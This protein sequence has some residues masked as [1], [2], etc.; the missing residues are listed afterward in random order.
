MHTRVH[1][2]IYLLLLCMTAVGEEDEVSI[3]DV[4]LMV[5]KAMNFEGKVIVSACTWEC[6]V[7]TNRAQSTGE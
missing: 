5:A 6:T 7:C 4:A 3:R 1:V 2:T